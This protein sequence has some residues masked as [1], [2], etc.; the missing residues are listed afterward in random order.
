MPECPE[1]LAVARPPKAHPLLRRIDCPGPQEWFAAGG[2]P[3]WAE[4]VPLA[5]ETA[6]TM[7]ASSPPAPPAPPTPRRRGVR[8]GN[9]SW[10]TGSLP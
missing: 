4:A 10:H 2:V 6:S 1:A 3:W 9:R 8:S 7:G 5:G